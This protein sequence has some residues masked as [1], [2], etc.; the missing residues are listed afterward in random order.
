MENM[1]EP[2][3]HPILVHFAY[4]LSITAFVSY[5]LAAFAPVGKW[6]E[7]LRPAADWMLAFG[8]LAILAT[9]AAGLQAYYT[10]AHDGPSHAA[11]T[12]HRNWAIP[13]GAV[14]LLLALW[15]W[16][17]RAKAAS[18]LFI[19]FLAAAAISLSVTAWWGGKI[20]YGYGLGV[21]SMPVVTGEGHDHEHAPGQGHGDNAK[22]PAADDH[23]KSDGHHDADA[24][25]EAEHDNSDGHH[26]NDAPAKAEHDNS[27]GHHDNDSTKSAVSPVV[28]VDSPE[29]A[30]ESYG[31]ALRAGDEAT[32]RAMLAPD[33]IIAE[34]GGAE[35]SVEE[36]AGHHMPADM[37]FTAAV[38]FTLKKR[39]VIATDDLATVISES[40]VHGT[41]RDQ[42]IHSRM[43]ETMVLKRENGQWRIVHIHWSSAPITGEHEH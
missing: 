31:V 24:T 8:A 26:D 29:A 18:T 34:G 38:E 22:T 12:V 4:A 6:R 28:D 41:F 1:I 16:R 19:A 20:V 17:N 30:V 9:I 37:A 7:T 35:R 43:M 36:Y 13:S 23:D 32:L 25:D 2:N 33:V 5:A 39:D 40:Q 3:I 21:K 10:V 42:T 27:D 14:I 15:R 11:M